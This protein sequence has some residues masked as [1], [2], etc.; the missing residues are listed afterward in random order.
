NCPGKNAPAVAE[1]T[2]T[3][4][5]CLDRRVPDAVESLRAGKWEKEEYAKALGL[6]GRRIGIVGL[7]HAGR[8]VARLAHAYEMELHGWSRGLHAQDATELGIHRALS[9]EEL[10]SRVDILTLHI[11]L[12]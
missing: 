10:A 12:S 9:V 8:A 2:M 1:L 6:R 11:E 3:L 7:G 4:I 5:G